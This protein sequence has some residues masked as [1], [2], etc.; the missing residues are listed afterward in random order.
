MLKIYLRDAWRHIVWDRSFTVISILGLAMGMAACVLISLFVV[1]ELSYDRFNVNAERIYRIA[2][3]IHINGGTT[4]NIMTPS[5]MGAALVKDFPAVETAVRVRALREG[6]IVHAGGKEFSEYGAVMADRTLFGVFSLPMIAGDPE[7]ALSSPNSL[8]VSEAAAQRY[9]H[10]TDVLGQTL[11]LDNDTTVYV[12]T[13][14]IKNMPAESHF[15]FQLIKPMVQR[16]QDWVN[17]YAATYILV[18]PGFSTADVDRILAETVSKYVNPQIQRDLHTSADGLKQS[19]DYFRYYAMPL[20]RIHL[21]SNLGLEFEPNGSIEYVVLFAVV[22]LL[23][24]GMAGV[25]FVN[26]RVARGIRRL[27]ATG[28]RK[29]LGSNRRQLAAQFMME[30]VLM[31]LLALGLAIGLVVL[32]L[33]VFNQLTGKSFSAFRMM[34]PMVMGDSLLVLSPMVVGCGLLVTLGVAILAGLYPALQLSGVQALDILRGDIGL[35][36]RKETFRTALLIFQFSAAMILII[37]TIVIHSQLSYIRH[38]DLGYTREQVVTIKGTR[39]LGD[40]VWTF[41]DAVRQLPGVVGATVSGSLPQQKV[42]YRGFFKDRTNTATSTVLLGDYHID[43]R[44]L[45]ALGMKLVKG[46]NFSSRLPTDSGCVLINE[47]A[48]RV[49]GY[50]NPMDQQLYTYGNS[51]G[52]RIIGVVRDFNTGSL[53]N[54]IDPVVFELRPDGGA[55]TIR[56]SPGDVRGTLRNIELQFRGIANGYP[57]DYTFLDEDFNR[58]Y[59]GD[60]RTGNLFSIFA[61]LAIV[62]AAIGMFGLVA[63]A[64]EQRT[65]EMSIR[66][67]LGARVVDISILLFKSYAFAIGM[68]VFVAVPAGALVMNRWLEGFAYR[69]SLQAWMFLIAPFCAVAVVIFIVGAKAWRATRVTPTRT[70][71]A[72]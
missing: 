30:S 24:L 17:L 41:A 10:F 61:G 63:A 39:S 3:D 60:Q 25:N 29:V 57:F 13:G 33:P 35:G 16:R 12:V 53:H 20:T 46:R 19:G 2:S 72:E 38:R 6:V 32:L 48:A 70:L 65:K 47:T 55:I 68:A 69:I 28:I 45:S 5:P 43:D 34:S 42:V 66:R 50:V 37:G 21:Y 26:L 49:L 36:F 64:A 54:P 44:Y 31:T 71:R 40:K 52:L 11:R 62:I 4:N 58:L 9:F 56:L 23:I 7:S 67:V 1:D 15:H 18:R 22:A 27:R 59:R 14:V 8:V 51:A